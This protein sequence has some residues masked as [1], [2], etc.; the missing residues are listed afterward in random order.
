MSWENTNVLITG[1]LGFIGSTLA[2]DLAELD[3]SV[4]LLDAKL[5]DYGANPANVD[6]IR[7]NVTIVEADLRDVKDVA[8]YVTQS[9]V[10]F[11]L[12]AQ[13]S[14]TVSNENPATDAEINCQGFLNVLSVAKSATDSP[15][16]VFTSS[17]AVVGRPASLP[18]DE[19]TQAA[20]L[21]VYGA[22]KRAGELYCNLYYES[23]GVPTVAVRLTNVYGPRAQLSNPNYG[24]INNFIAAAL[25]D[26][27][28]TVFEPGTMKRDF[29]YV[30][31]I[32]RGLRC[33]GFE[34]RAVGER[35]TLGTGDATTIYDLAEAIVDTAGSGSVKLVPWPDDWESIQVGD[36]RSDPSKMCD[37]FDWEPETDLTE[38]LVETIDY[39]RDNLEAYL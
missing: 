37:H 6:T 10:V 34:Q 4:T 1:G 31:D 25:R 21:D 3:A 13:L 32:T 22:N 8:P 11:H 14:R 18:F 35:Y 29:V 27:T 39:Y 23:H 2:H 16:I 33:L 19:T 9:D 24:V 26:E 5:E 12:A 30:R 20:P 17:Q 7:D 38:G 28:L 36:L 15:R